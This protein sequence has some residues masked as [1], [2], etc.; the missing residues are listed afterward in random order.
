MPESD[1]PRLVRYNGDDID[2]IKV[3]SWLNLFEVV[4]NTQK[5]DTDQKKVALLMSYLGK[6]A[7]QW[8][9]DEVAPCCMTVTWAKVKQDMEERFGQTIASPVLTAQQRRL[10]KTETVQA[11][12]TEKMRI[13]RKTKLEEADMIALLTD[14]LPRHYQQSM[15]AA[16]IKSTNDW[17]AIAIKLESAFGPYNPRLR[18]ANNAQHPTIQQTVEV[19]KATVDK[20]HAACG[21]KKKPFKPCY[22]CKKI[23]KTEWHWHSECPHAPQK[24]HA[25]SSEPIAES[26]TVTVP[27]N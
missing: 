14:G 17:L 6:D 23:G 19:H 11:Y 1:K 25:T 8:Y 16:R 20:P 24:P 22:Y 5:A 2:S 18:D 15:I 4:A 7:L 9:A 27:K 13:L 26:M 3:G 21:Q 12:H 10:L